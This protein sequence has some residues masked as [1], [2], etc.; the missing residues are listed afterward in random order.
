MCDVRNEPI[1][2][3]FLSCTF[4][5]VVWF[6]TPLSFLIDN[7]MHASFISWWESWMERKKAWVIDTNNQCIIGTDGVQRIHLSFTKWIN[8]LEDNQEHF[9]HANHQ[10]A[11][12][13][14]HDSRINARIFCDGAV[15][16]AV[17]R[18]GIECITCNNEG[19]ILV[20]ISKCKDGDILSWSRCLQ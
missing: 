6:G 1:E 16:K 9:T 7:H 10:E 19:S 15:N 17:N 13:N 2:H 5:C 14:E 20:K 4:A 11:T 12:T 3:L 8:S 18:L